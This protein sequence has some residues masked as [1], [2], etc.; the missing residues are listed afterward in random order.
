MIKYFWIAL[1]LLC[2]LLFLFLMH[3]V[4]KEEALAFDTYI[5]ELLSVGEILFR[6]LS[7]SQLPILGN[8]SSL[9]LEAYFVFYICG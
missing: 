6:S 2:V 4:Q 5:T 1:V 3:E 9:V 7:S 8:P